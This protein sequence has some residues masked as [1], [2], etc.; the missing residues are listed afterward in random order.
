MEVL[1]RYSLAYGLDINQYWSSQTPASG[2][3]VALSG[4][5]FQVSNS[6]VCLM[7]NADNKP[8]LGRQCRQW[9]AARASAAHLRGRRTVHEHHALER[10]HVVADR[11]GGLQMRVR[12]RLRHPLHEAAIWFAHKLR[13]QHCLVYKTKF[14]TPSTIPC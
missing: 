11:H 9:R 2:S 8:E 7:S 4:L 5:L 10:E 1:T 3:G 12:V 6:F 13:Y 14:V